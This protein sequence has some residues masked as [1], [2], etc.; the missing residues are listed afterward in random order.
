MVS[1][2]A[3]N[4]DGDGL[5]PFLALSGEVYADDPYYSAPLRRSVLASLRRADFRDRQQAFLA[6]E[7]GRPMARVVA[8]QSSRLADERGQGYGLLGFFEARN[9]PPAVTALFDQ[10]IGWLRGQGT[11]PIVGPMDGD[12]WHSYRL[13]VGPFDSRPF[14]M[15]PYNPPYYP[16]LWRVNGFEVLESY[17]SKRVEDLP[18]VINALAPKFERAVAAGYRFEQLAIDRLEVELERFYELSCEIF[19]DNFLYTEISRERFLSLYLGSRALLDPDLVTF[20]RAPDGSDVGF[21]FALPDRFRAVAAMQGETGLWAKLRFLATRR[22]V[23]TVNLKSLGVTSE[24]RMGGLGAALMCHAYKTA[25]EKG[26][27]NANLCLILDG[28]PSGRM[29]GG[30]SDVLRRYEL[31]QLARGSRHDC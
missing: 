13:N 18:A 25:H 9:S 26:Y 7:H 10:A 20:A 16:D 6:S 29:E 12:T 24:H 28:N 27:E 11:G 8:R 4:L 5:E 3:I 21:L 15:E 19:A 1:V 17:C 22:R 31:Y 30:R 14:L 2:A 23:D